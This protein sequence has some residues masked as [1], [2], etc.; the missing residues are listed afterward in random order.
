MS[1]PS[2]YA[3]TAEYFPHDVLMVVNECIDSMFACHVDK[4]FHDI[5]VGFIILVFLGLHSCPHH[6]Q[7]DAIETEARAINYILL[8]E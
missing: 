6:S 8:G 1:K 2:W 7:T 5:K 3:I 4:I